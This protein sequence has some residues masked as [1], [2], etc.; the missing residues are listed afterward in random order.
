MWNGP[1]WRTGSDCWGFQGNSASIIYQ[2]VFCWWAHFLMVRWIYSNMHLAFVWNLKYV[3][4][5]RRTRKDGLAEED[6]LGVLSKCVPFKPWDLN[7]A[8]AA[9][10]VQPVHT[11]AHLSLPLHSLWENRNVKCPASAASG[12]NQSMFTNQIWNIGSRL[13]WSVLVKE[14]LTV[15][16]W[17][18]DCRSSQPLPFFFGR[19]CHQPSHCCFV[20]CTGDWAFSHHGRHRR[21][22]TPAV[23]PCRFLF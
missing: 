4:L 13:P 1:E 17:A 10:S 9:V 21:L 2:D 11:I 3:K 23:W 18:G 15:L 8:S 20:L 16:S 5:G 6:V 7:S 14:P 22:L 19:Q 12:K